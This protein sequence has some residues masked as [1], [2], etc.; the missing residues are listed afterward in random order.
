MYSLK[1]N[2]NGLVKIVYIEERMI[3]RDY[4]SL[5][6]GSPCKYSWKSLKFKLFSFSN[7]NYEFQF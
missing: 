3:S 6:N 2:F 1:S 7:S 4:F 5:R